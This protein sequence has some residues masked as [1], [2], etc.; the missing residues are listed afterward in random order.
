MTATIVTIQCQPVDA[1]DAHIGLRGGL[2]RCTPYRRR[3]RTRGCPRVCYCHG[4]VHAKCPDA[5]PCIGGCG[6]FTTASQTQVCG[7]C[8][9][10]AA[11]QRWVK[12][13]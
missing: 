6:R 13:A 12:I 1:A 11:D 9:H 10:C 5:K 7:Y 4:E 8:P 3:M 2:C